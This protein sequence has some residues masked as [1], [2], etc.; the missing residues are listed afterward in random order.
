MG[1]KNADSREP[2]DTSYWKSYNDHMYSCPRGCQLS[3][4]IKGPLDTPRITV[5]NGTQGIKVN[6]ELGAYHTDR[7]YEC[8]L[9]IQGYEIIPK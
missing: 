9:Q 4:S 8:L 7:H 1:P 5:E 3:E 2:I 6:P